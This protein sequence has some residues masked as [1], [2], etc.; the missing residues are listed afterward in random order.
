[1]KKI[2]IIYLT[3][4]GRSGGTLLGRILGNTAEAIYVGE[5]RYFWEKGIIKNYECS[6]NERFSNCRFWLEV[7]N[8]YKNEAALED[9]ERISKELEQIEKLKNYSTLKKI[10][11][12]QIMNNPGIQKYLELNEKLYES[13]VTVSGKN[14]IV[15]SSR[16][17]GR[18]LALSLSNKLELLPIHLIRDPRGVMNSLINQDIRNYGSVKHSHLRRILEWNINN[19]YSLK[20]IRELNTKQKFYIRYENFVRYPAK[21]LRRLEE[22]LG[23]TFDYKDENG[24]VSVNLDTGHVF[25]GNES[26]FKAGVIRITEDTKWKIELGRQ[27]KILIGITTLPLFKYIT[28]K[29]HR[30]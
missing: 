23:Y 2:R 12:N 28:K 13:I 21:V 4:M 17:P 7:V 26:R 22:V 10:K 15:E 29:Y 19:I 20:S 25:S 30:D 8:N 6:C 11:Q 9:I 27:K 5:L 1:M 24:I 18:L 14:T 16:I 3:G